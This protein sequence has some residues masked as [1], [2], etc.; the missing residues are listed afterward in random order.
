MLLPFVPF[1][2][3]YKIIL[4]ESARGVLNSKEM[5]VHVSMYRF[6]SL[7]YIHTIVTSTPLIRRVLART[8][9]FIISWLHTHS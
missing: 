6:I 4:R 8:I 2:G 3:N 7:P 9:G 1:I 5:T